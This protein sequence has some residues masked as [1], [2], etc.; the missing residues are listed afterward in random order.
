MIGINSRATGRGAV[1]L[2]LIVAGA[3][4]T[5]TFSDDLPA[6][7]AAAQTTAAAP[8]P[9]FPGADAFGHRIDNRYFPLLPGAAY[10]YKGQEDGEVQRRTMKVTHATRNILGVQAVVVLDTVRDAK[11]GLVEQTH[12][13]FA[14]DDEGNVWY[15]GEDS[16]A[17]AHG[18]VVSTEGS[19]EAGVDG[20]QPGI[21]MPGQ[22]RVGDA[23]SQE[24]APG[25]AQD[26]AKTLSLHDAART[27]FG[28]FRQTLRSRESTPL[29]PRVLEDKWYA[30]CIG[31]VHGEDIRGGK[32]FE[33]LVDVKHAPDLAAIGCAKQTHGSQQ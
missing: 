3:T 23:Y 27:P 15:L 28:T 6:A 18:K 7:R 11:G 21:I 2:A 19:W 1:V 32:G 33:A 14:Q 10:F 8:C 20:A 31:V 17:Y 4:L 5:T 29:E 26:A 24:C 30:P 13:W 22:P 25:V 16:K 9:S 12:D